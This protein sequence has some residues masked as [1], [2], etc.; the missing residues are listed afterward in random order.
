MSR[1][2]MDC[3][4][5]LG[6]RRTTQSEL[7]RECGSFDLEDSAFRTIARLRPSNI[8]LTGQWSVYLDQPKATGGYITADPRGNATEE[9]SRAA[10]IAKIPETL[11][12]LTRIAKVL[13]IKGTPMLHAT[14]EEG[15]VN[16]PNGFEPTL[17]EYRAYE[18]FP[19]AVIDQAAREIPGVTV[20]D[21]T[22]MLCDQ[23]KC[24]AIVGGVRM[25]G[26]YD[27][28]HLSDPGSLLFLPKLEALVK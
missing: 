10:L 4:P 5:L 17:S 19:N 7:G 14:T 6:M 9:T 27:L 16:D 24:H 25:Y 28:V 11:R 26:A 22:Y 12:R 3:P 21:P 23:R 20:L 2:S 18:A 8:I 15:L 1:S 13:I